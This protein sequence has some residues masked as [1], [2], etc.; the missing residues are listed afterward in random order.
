MF[1]MHEDRSGNLWIATA[2]SGLYRSDGVGWRDYFALDEACATRAPQSVSFS[3]VLSSNLITGMLL[4][5][6]A[7]L[8]FATDDGGAARYDHAGNW[9]TFRRGP[10]MPIGD[11]LGTV[12][13]DRR[14]DLWFGSRGRGVA[15]FDSARAG[16]LA[17]TR[18]EGLSSDT[19]RCA[20][21]D[22]HGDLWLGTATGVSRWDGTTWRTALTGP[23]AGDGIR[24]EAIVEDAG[25]RLWFRT[26]DG[27]YGLDA[28]RAA[29]TRVTYA[30]GLADDAVTALAVDATGQVQVGTPR[31]LSSFDGSGWTTLASFGAPR[32]SAV[33]ALLL[34]HAGRL[35]VGLGMGVAF[36]DGDG[37][38]HF[39]WRTFPSVPVLHLFEDDL[40]T[41]WA[42]A[43]GGLARFNGDSWRVYDHND[44]LVADA[45]SGFLQ[46]ETGS[47]W[48][49]SVNS[50]LTEHQPDRTA[51]QTV[52][53]SVP[54]PLS[55]SRDADLVFGAGYGESADLE[56]SE[57]LDDGGDSPWSALVSLSRKGLADGEHVFS[58]RARDWSRNVDPTPAR[59]AWEVDATPPNAILSAPVFGQPVRGVLEVR[60]SATDPR[61]LSYRVDAR[62]V[63]ATRW[64]I[65]IDSST[66]AVGDTLLARW[67]TRTAD[68]G[69]Y[70]LRLAVLDTLGLMG[71]AQVTVIVDNAA[72]WA[73]VTTPARVSALS[74]G[75]VYTTHQEI[76]LYFPPRAF[77]EDAVVSVTPADPP[78]ATA[79]PPSAAAV[80]AGYG[81][82]WSVEPLAKTATLEFALP[83]SVVL[84]ANATP[85]IYMGHGDEGW[86]R[87]G[88]TFDAA[89]RVVSTPVTAPGR[90]AI[91]LDAGGGSGTGGIAA[92]ELTPRV[93]SPSGGFA[94]TSAAISFTLARPAST[95]VTVFNRA[96]RRVRRVM[97]DRP[98]G[99][100]ANLVRWDGRN[101]D[102]GVVEDG[103]YLV[104]IEALGE[105]R[106]LPVAVVR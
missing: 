16:W 85:A 15:R 80:T 46:D 105:V 29:W 39:G 41:I 9:S 69:D 84:Q 43:D 40:H 7:D 60:G 36:R 26:S 95:T 1:A 12:F 91:V 77:R 87:L 61:F 20:F 57:S 35:W 93:F 28:A 48:F 70:D 67:D 88:G 4:D 27:L 64:S 47:L 71:L 31:G 13:E 56:F 44:G 99:A 65:P 33:Q 42:A 8:W 76:H 73:D 25:G 68:E 81:I 2:A 89:R 54:V 5:H 102:G 51:P 103:M 59:V 101:D 82:A 83:D 55:I 100:G 92:L 14:G 34:D 17:F 3:C 86:T 45:V 6:H 97:S 94:G 104:A 37:W 21:Q 24:V 96:G 19:V 72:P 98:L 22:R 66:V 18:A 11:S 32:D 74:G 90:Y 53:V 79:L 58:V 62:P 63:G 52:L 78:P 49:S 10:G 106:K 75:D 50:G 30:D 23:G 38:T